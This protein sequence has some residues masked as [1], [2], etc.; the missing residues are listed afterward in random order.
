MSRRGGEATFMGVNSQ[1][2]AAL[3]IFLQFIGKDDFVGMKLET[4]K[5]VDFMLVFN[6]KRRIV[7]E[8]KYRSKPLSL[9]D[10]KEI[11]DNAIKREQTKKD[12]EFL[13][14][15]KEASESVKSLINNF[16]FS[17]AIY[18]EE[19]I[20]K[21]HGFTEK[22]FEVLPKVRLWE[23]S[24]DVNKKGILILMARVINM[25]ESFWVPFKTLKTWCND[26]LVED[27]YKGSQKGRT[28]TKNKFLMAL[29]D[30]KREYLKEHGAEYE[31][32]KD[33]DETRVGGLI[34]T[35]N[36][37]PPPSRDVCAT[38]ISN[39]I[40]SPNLHYF[41]LD[42]LSNIQQKINLKP[43]DSLWMATVQSAFSVKVFQI[44]ENNLTNSSNQKYI[45][46]FL[47]SILK[48][49]YF[50]YFRDDFFIHDI[51]DLCKKL[52]E[53]NPKL[54]KEIFLIIKNLF[55]FNTQQFMYERHR[56]DNTFERET[57][58][59]LLNQIYNQST[60]NTFKEEIVK[61]II[62]VFNIV[63]DD[64]KFWHY[65]PSELFQI[66]EN[67]VSAD[68]ENRIFWL[69]GVVTEQYTNYYKRF[70]K[71]VSFVGWEHMGSG[72]AQSGSEYSI[73]DKYFVW[74]VLEP[75]IKKTGDREKVWQFMTTK[76]IT[77]NVKDVCKE[78]PDYF[79]RSCLNILLEEYNQNKYPTESFEILSSFIKMHK[80]IPW[81]SDLIFQAVAKGNLPAD[82]KW[83][84]I[85]VSLDE[86]KHLPVNVFV[87]QI[88]TELASCDV[89]EVQTK[90]IQTIIAWAKN[91]QYRNNR[92]MG[93]YDIIDSVFRLVNNVNT[94]DGGIEIL[95]S[96]LNSEEFINSKDNYGSWDV[97]KALAL[98]IQKDEEKGLSLLR[99]INSFGH[100]T[101]TQQLV[102]CSTLD[103]L[104]EEKSVL[105][106]LF[107]NFL[108]PILNEFDSIDKFEV[109]FSEKYAREQLA[110]LSEKLAK[111]GEYEKALKII[112]LFVHD[113]DPPKD[114]SNYP[115]DPKGEF[116]KHKLIEDGKEDFSI[117]TVRGR[118]A[119]SL[120]HFALSPA[121]KFV[122]QAVPLVKKLV[123]DK[124]NYIRLQATFALIEFVKN[125]DTY[126][127][128]EEPKKRFIDEKT[129]IVIEEMALSM[130]RDPNNQKMPAIMKGMVHVFGNWRSVD[131]GLA[132]E[133][134]N[135][136]INTGND[137]VIQDVAPLLVFFAIFRKNAFSK[138][139]WKTL[140]KFDGTAIERK[141]EEQIKNGKDSMKHSLSWQFWQ[142]PK[143]GLADISTYDKEVFKISIKY[144]KMFIGQ[145]YDHDVWQDV[146]YFIEDF[147]PF[148]FEAC[149][150]LW[151]LCLV[152]EKEYLI[153]EVKKK[154]AVYKINWW[155]HFYNGRVLLRI[156]EREHDVTNPK[157]FL[158]WLNFLSGYPTGVSIG[159]DI[160]EAIVKLQSLASPDKRI[161]RI[162]KKLFKRDPKYYHHKQ[163]WLTKQSL[164]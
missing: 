39:L 151:K 75:A 13:I 91:P 114:G 101:T 57:V 155:P 7:C 33:Y 133:I 78:R 4:Q 127:R 61:F 139:P 147:I 80:G 15:T 24:Q 38:E 65:T 77:T 158:H 56:G 142:L 29:S 22:H 53:T 47:T 128:E 70:N 49:H 21:K 67:Y 117:D 60:D 161:E 111:V 162:Y 52:F 129:A 118:C 149:Y 11:L 153:K 12:D 27:I 99:E 63:D 82:K 102:I 113:S 154:D 35:I 64:G 26:L 3:S 97:A 103:D 62:S 34:K 164:G 140:P 66:I 58:A 125:K 51:S 25:N 30:K 83:N 87:E 86:Y 17:E 89:E 94:I 120:R 137:D 157:H 93:S 143:Q 107:D 106:S 32:V 116:N 92:S 136:F 132:L 115:D 2:V 159:N 79:N 16:K 43:W 76:L 68:P 40:T 131:Q 112:K 9:N 160:D 85:K 156:L 48:K 84:L 109:R 42:N 19:L 31:K 44:F 123:N 134:L 10:L 163:S 148:E 100:L 5:L 141:L 105:I 126:I 135:V 145:G 90:A 98:I 119:W 108:E 150:E 96:Y 1:A 45:I 122:K 28:I 36:S 37:D 54:F 8:S 41:A 124:N 130:L 104:P 74:Q 72:I 18:K 14:I 6:N 55:E 71:K 46:E 88:V 81:K 23:V 59:Q 73:V 50:N 20:N 69:S 152:P 95:R 110:S 146:Y 138:W 144:L 121:R